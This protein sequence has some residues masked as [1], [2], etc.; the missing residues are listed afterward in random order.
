GPAG[1]DASD[2]SAIEETVDGGVGP[3]APIQ[4]D[5]DGSGNANGKPEA[6]R[7]GQCHPDPLPRRPAG[8]VGEH[9]DRPAS[10]DEMV[11]T[12]HRGTMFDRVTQAR[13]PSRRSSCHNARMPGEL[14]SSSDK[15]PAATICPA[16]SS[17]IRSARVRAAGR[18]DTT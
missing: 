8:P 17:R 7:G 14:A 5:Q 11:T 2:A 6:G 16:S 15:V 3:V 12:D 1:G 18:W 13:R 4:L 9:A 10:D